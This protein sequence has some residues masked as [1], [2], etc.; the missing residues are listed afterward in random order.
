M[1]QMSEIGANRGQ[2][3]MRLRLTM[4]D[5]TAFAPD[6]PATVSQMLEDEARWGCFRVPLSD[7]HAMSAL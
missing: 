4:D 7:S 1:S 5:S 6:G 2:P 3:D